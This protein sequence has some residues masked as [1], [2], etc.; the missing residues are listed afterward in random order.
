MS[1]KENKILLIDDDAEIR[2]SLDRVLRQDGHLVI[3]A[4]SEK[5]A[6]K[7]RNK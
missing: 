1:P 6:L 7:K 3:S 4:D 5:T 2:Y